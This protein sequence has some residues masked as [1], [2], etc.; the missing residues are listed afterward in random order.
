MKCTSLDQEL[1]NKKKKVRFTAHLVIH[2][3]IIQLFLPDCTSGLLSCLAI[4]PDNR[5]TQSTG[6]PFVQS[7]R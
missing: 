4:A 7:P 2:S 3:L 6:Y 1:L 5:S